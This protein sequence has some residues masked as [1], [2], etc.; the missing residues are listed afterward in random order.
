MRIK[1]SLFANVNRS[2][3]GRLLGVGLTCLLVLPVVAKEAPKLT[4]SKA[5][6]DRSARGV[7]Y[8]D[9]IK[10]VTPSVVTIESTRTIELRHSASLS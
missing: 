2:R 6:V 3:W 5:A 4:I 9:T 1:R 7:S 10:K 8:A